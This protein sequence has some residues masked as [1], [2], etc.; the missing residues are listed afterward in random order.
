[1]VCGFFV[2]GSMMMTYSHSIRNQ[3][4]IPGSKTSIMAI[5]MLFELA[6]SEAIHCGVIVAAISFAMTT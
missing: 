1:M 3:S 5:S 6:V 2:T 4:M